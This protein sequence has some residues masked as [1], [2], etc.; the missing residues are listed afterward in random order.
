M[1]PWMHGQ[2]FARRRANLLP[3][4]CALLLL[5]VSLSLCPRMSMHRCK[6]QRRDGE[7][8]YHHSYFYLY[9]TIP[10]S[11]HPETH[12][13]VYTPPNWGVYTHHTIIM[14]VF[15]CVCVC[16][17][18]CVYIYFFLCHSGSGQYAGRRRKC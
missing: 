12:H 3:V 17:C 18:V 2:L 14:C 1:A 7:E 13:H 10:P 8:K 6:E 15:V 16:V 11:L 9:V 5:Q 4:L